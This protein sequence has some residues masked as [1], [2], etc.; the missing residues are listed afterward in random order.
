MRIL[1]I[2]PYAP[3]LVRV[4]SYQLIRSLVEGGHQVVLGTLWS[5]EKELKDIEQI[6]KI[7]DK[8]IAFQ[9]P[10]V[11]SMIN[12]SL[13]LFSKKPLQYVYCWEPRLAKELEDY[14]RKNEE[15]I[16]VIHVEHLRGAM[17]GCMLKSFLTQSNL[18]IPI[19]W[20]SVDSISYLF[21]QSAQQNR[22]IFKR[23]LMLFE[24][25]RTEL[26][27]QY[28]A[29]LFAHVLVTSS[30]D[31]D[32]FLSLKREGEAIKK[33]HISILPNGVDLEYFRPPDGI[34]RETAA[35][36]VS[37]KMS[38]H[39]NISMTL[40]LVKE[41]MPLIWKKRPEVKLWIVGKDPHREI[42]K[43]A[44]NPL[45]TVTGTVP[46]LRAYLQRATIAVAPLVYGAGIQNK[47][48]EAMACATPVVTSP[49]AM[50]ALE[51]VPGRDLEQANTPGEYA[52]KIINLL[53][54][55]SY[56]KKIGSA[57]RSYVENHHRWSIIAEGLTLIYHKV[58]HHRSGGIV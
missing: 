3:S 20:D 15:T 38:Y 44:E 29:N 10:R 1:F 45:I 39:A 27:E 6:R 13:G 11:R 54:S 53:A 25:N 28:L 35:L 55:P 58:N 16:D 14:I 8:V 30:V 9:L 51:A 19:I 23:W 36:V 5:D 2:V 7:C 47:V 41:I 34:N 43:L 40:Y 32:V 21:K 33:E 52:E 48:L 18:P 56:Q 4:R 49:Q 46:D 50:K 31:R 42:R 17:Y 26:Y 24:L 22:Q 37:G 57:G 12:C